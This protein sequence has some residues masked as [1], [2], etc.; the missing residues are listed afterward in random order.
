VE[1][2][3]LLT[4]ALGLWRERGSDPMVAQTLRFLS[5]VNRQMGLCEG[6]DRTGEEKRW[7]STKGLATHRCKQVPDQARFPASQGRTARRSRRS[8][9]ARNRSHRGERQPISAL[10]IALVLSA[11]YRSKG[12]TEKAISISRR[13]SKLQPPSAGT[14]NY[15]GTTIPLRCCFATTADSRTHRP[16]SNTPSRTRSTAHTT[17][18]MCDAAAS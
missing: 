12:E 2:K 5:D 1:C 10:R 9:I 11:I 18:L 8:S 6:R 3:R 16:T 13:P 14:M 15:F 4:H 7:K 17:S